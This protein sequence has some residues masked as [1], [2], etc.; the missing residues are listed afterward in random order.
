MDQSVP[1]TSGISKQGD[2]K[3]QDLL[4]KTF[5]SVQ[6]SKKVINGSL[7]ILEEVS[8][9]V[10][11]KMQ[12]G[13]GIVDIKSIG[14][15]S[16][17]D[18]CVQN[19][20]IVAGLLRALLYHYGFKRGKGRK[21]LLHSIEPL[22]LDPS[23]TADIQQSEAKI[24]AIT[25]L[26]NSLAF[27]NNTDET[28][29]EEEERRATSRAAVSGLLPTG[30]Y[31][32]K[33]HKL[34]DSEKS[35]SISEDNV[36]VIQT[37][38]HFGTATSENMLRLVIDSH[39]ENS[40]DLH[41]LT[42]YI[43]AFVSDTSPLTSIASQVIRNQLHLREDNIFNEN[44]PR[45]KVTKVDAA[46][47]LNLAAEVAP[48]SEIPPRLLVDVS[49][50]MNLQHA[51]ER[52][53]VSAV[54]SSNTSQDELHE[55]VQSLIDGTSENHQYRQADAYS[56][57]FYDY[58]GKSRFAE[59]RFIHACDTICKVIV[60]RQFPIIERQVERVD[61]AF[62]RIQKDHVINEEAPLRNGPIEIREFALS[63]LRESN[64]HD[65]A[66]R[67]ASLWEMEY[68]YDEKDV[69]KYIQARKSR[70]LQW[71]NIF[72]RD[73]VIPEEISCPMELRSKFEGMIQTCHKGE[74]IGFD[75]EWADDIPGAALLQL[76][77]VS[78][79]ILVDIPKLIESSEGCEALHDTIGKI[80]KGEYKRK[81]SDLQFVPFIVGFSCREDLKRLSASS[82]QSKVSWFEPDDIKYF[83]D[84]K[85][86]LSEE[87]EKLKHLG[88]SRICELYFKKPLD[89]SEQCSLWSRRP[90]SESQRIYAALDAWAVAALW[91]KIKQH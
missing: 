90:L 26:I 44:S 9:R 17:N 55:A 73:T 49:L 14:N 23:S 77:T 79:A 37:M 51:A 18:V 11:D 39:G 76:S 62:E 4:L 34:G 57:E 27:T 5:S 82:K 2:T 20:L 72:Q 25:L 31:Q 91:T 16:E 60:K 22:F 54:Q 66:H 40:I 28:V 1:E 3:L 84:I 56:T 21:A 85:P 87:N 86:F 81:D 59:A 12:E 71:E 47:A 83:R 43:R 74:C 61:K 48:W 75:V 7:V 69:E 38:N 6:I 35:V 78:F 33:K 68:I 46:A 45:P 58:G 42:S 30:R 41:I 67:L 13:D 29:D 36:P 64:L 19:S 32:N 50:S 89:K 52:I 88:L 80:F 24:L 65:I 53:C 10:H 70:Y 8:S 15:T 63:Q